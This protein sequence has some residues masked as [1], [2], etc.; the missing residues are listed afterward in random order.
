MIIAAGKSSAL[1][2]RSAQLIV[3]GKADGDCLRVGN[4]PAGKSRDDRR[5]QSLWQY[6]R[7]AFFLQLI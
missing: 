5:Y 3:D 1:S 7:Q 6:P 4:L 2:S